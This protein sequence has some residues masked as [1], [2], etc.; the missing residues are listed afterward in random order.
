MHLN[1]I[2]K[3]KAPSKPSHLGDNKSKKPITYYAYSKEGHIARDC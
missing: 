2:N 3:G 1:N